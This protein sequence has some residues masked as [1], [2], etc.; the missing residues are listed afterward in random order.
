MFTIKYRYFEP[1]SL[2]A[3]KPGSDCHAPGRPTYTEAERIDGPYVSVSQRWENG[4]A[5]VTADRGDVSPGMTYGPIINSGDEVEP[6]MPYPRPTLWVMN[7]R[8]ATIAKYDL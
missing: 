3:P 5:I 1:G 6:N 4:Y 7:D 8:G 2:V